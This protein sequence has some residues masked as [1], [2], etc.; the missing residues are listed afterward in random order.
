MVRKGIWWN[1]TWISELKNLYLG[2]W[3]AAHEKLPT[4]TEESLN[5][6]GHSPGQ[7]E[8]ITVLSYFQRI[9]STSPTPWF[10][11]LNHPS[12]YLYKLGLPFLVQIHVSLWIFAQQLLTALE[13]AGGFAGDCAEVWQKLISQGAQLPAFQSSLKM[14]IKAAFSFPWEGTLQVECLFPVLILGK[15]LCQHRRALIMCLRYWS[16]HLQYKACLQLVSCFHL[17]LSLQ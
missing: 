11:D 3:W 6:T 15:C 12:F 1:R 9:H 8:Q 10:C 16:C 4:E 13:T 2:G 5:L 7:P 17:S 14:L